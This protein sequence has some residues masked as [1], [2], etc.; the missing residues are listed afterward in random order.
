LPTE[1]RLR[2]GDWVEV[3]SAGEIL[4]TLDGRGRL[5]ALPFM[6]EMLE[7]CGRRFRVYKSAHKSC[8]TLRNGTRM[9]H[10]ADAVHLAGVRCGG[11][12]HGGCQALCLL[13]WK[14]D[15][16]KRV[17]GP[18]ADAVPA[19]NP[20]PAA[21]A[22]LMRGT[23]PPDA[24]PASNGHRYSCQATDLLAASSPVRWW[25]PRMLARDL[26]SRNVRLRDFIRYVATAVFNSAMRLHWRLREYPHVQGRCRD[27]TPNVTLDLQPGELVQVRS[28]EE[29]MDTLNEHNRN[30]GLSFDREMLPYCGK[31]FRVRSRVQR[32]VN[33][34]TG[35]LINIPGRCLILE[36]V[37]CQGCLSRNRVFCQRAIYPY[38][39]EVWL[40]RVNDTATAAQ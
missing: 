34:K 13:Y 7:Y 6:P 18:A 1:R 38:W 8:D 32:I 16:L 40:K 24:D 23:R 2:A 28:G 10:V 36:G 11:A 35:E 25:H 14:E 19:A 37:I 29:I 39:H 26:I 3:K 5:D 15:W 12:A 27:Q 30:R 21:L 9:R 31:T 17:A 4:A 33:D 20:E 22:I